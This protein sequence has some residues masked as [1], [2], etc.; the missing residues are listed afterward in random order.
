MH[1]VQGSRLILYICRGQTVSKGLGEDRRPNLPVGKPGPLH[2][3]TRAHPCPPPSKGATEEE[4]SPKPGPCPPWEP[5][6]LCALVYY[7]DRCSYLKK[8][9]CPFPHLHCHQQLRIGHHSSYFSL[10]LSTPSRV[11]ILD[12]WTH[13]NLQ[14]M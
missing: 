6:Q 9:G 4:S 5:S 8:N 3:P 11:I 10:S 1:C 12:W 14:I 7:Q 2:V 13:L